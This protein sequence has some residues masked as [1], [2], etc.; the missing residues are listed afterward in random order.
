VNDVPQVF[1]PAGD[2]WLYAYHA[3]TGDLIWKFD[4]NPKETKW[5]KTGRGKRNSVIATPVFYDNSVLIGVGDDPEF[6][7]SVGHLWRIDATKQ[8]D[9][10]SELGEI[11]MPGRPN[12]NSGQIWHYG[13]YDSEGSITGKAKK[14]I[15]RRTISTVVV[16]EGMVFASD[17]TGFMHCVD[18]KSGKRH[19]E[20]DLFG[21]VWASP[22]IVDGKLL[23]GNEEGV[24]FVFDAK[25]EKNDPVEVEFKGSIYGTPAVANRVLY[26]T[27]R[28][29][30]YA[31]KITGDE[32]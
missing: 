7:S 30:L 24:L 10:S 18:F 23:L 6:G 22:M 8:G 12:P 21:A 16:Y 4:L 27:D 2:G 1:M 13:G 15:F 9:I 29:N 26:M 19:W 14:E 31:I 28:T 25:S 20:Y 17:Y 3:K 11:G 5:E 32:K